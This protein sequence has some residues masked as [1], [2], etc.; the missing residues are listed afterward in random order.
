M[1]QQTT[2]EGRDYFTAERAGV[3][4]TASQD[5]IGWHVHSHRLALGRGNVGGVKRFA[6]VSDLATK[7][8]AFRGLDQ[9]VTA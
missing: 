5:C 3:R 2:H 9:L 7:V 6:S 8:K 4:Y 1:I